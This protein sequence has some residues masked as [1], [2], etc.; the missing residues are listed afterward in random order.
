VNKL[1]VII[2]AY[3]EAANLPQVFD[4]LHQELPQADILVVDDASA[5]DTAEAAKAHAAV[6]RLPFNMGYAGA[7]QCGF[8]YACAHQYERVLQFDGDGQ[9]SAKGV[10]K[11]LASD[12]DIVIGT[13]FWQGSDYPHP[14]M[15]KVGTHLFSMLIRLV[16]R[17]TITDP[18]SG[19]QVL[20]RRAFSH[21]ADLANYPDYPDANLIIEMLRTG[22]TIEEKPVHMRTR[23]SGKG[24]HDGLWKPTRY[25]VLMLYAVLLVSL[26]PLRKSGM[27]E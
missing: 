19:Y 2:P 3:N 25:M 13:R 10:D 9:H 14:F 22:F 5:D 20:S 15:R 6:L 12:A 26:K 18:T 23:I 27:K 7:L 21:Y 1:L 4:E 24:M 17:Q 11:L 8:K 16:C